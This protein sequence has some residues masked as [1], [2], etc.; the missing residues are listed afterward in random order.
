MAMTVLSAYYRMRPPELRP[1][2]KAKKPK[3]INRDFDIMVEIEPNRAV[4]LATALELD[5]VTR[6]EAI[7]VRA[8]LTYALP[9]LDTT[10]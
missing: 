5:L 10:Q 2:D 1:E 8:D 3:P 6:E 7:K 4:N 9:G